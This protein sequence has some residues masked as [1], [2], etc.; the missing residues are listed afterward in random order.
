MR[1][2]G[3]GEHGVGGGPT[4]DLYVVIAVEDHPFFQRDGD[5]LWCEV[6]VTFPTLALGGTIIGS[7]PR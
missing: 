1:V 3:E 7:D 5:D 4:G 2:Q 6:P